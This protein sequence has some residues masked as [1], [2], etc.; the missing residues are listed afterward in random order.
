MS[1]N[2]Y[3]INEDLQ[4]RNKEMSSFS[5]YV[6]GS[7][8]KEYRN[9]VDKVYNLAESIEDN[10]RREKALYYADKYSKSLAEWYNK[11]AEIGTRCPSVL[12]AGPSNFP[13]RKKEKQLAAWDSNMRFL[14]E[15]VDGYKGKIKQII[16]GQEIIHSDEDDAVK[17]LEDKLMLLK[18]NQERMKSA[19][20]ALKLKNIEEGNEKLHQLGYNDLS[21][22][23]LR[24]P[25]YMGRIGFP[26]WQLS[27]NN[28]NIH[29]IEGR[30]QSIKKAK[31]EA[32]VPSD[33]WNNEF[34]EVVENAE[35]MRI[36]L[37]FDGK[38]SEEV[39]DLLKHWGFRWSPRYTAWQRN[40][41]E[42]GKYAVKMVLKSLREGSAA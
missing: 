17:K 42:N 4:R 13:V 23:K 37:I 34:C 12:I 31:E 18:Q 15:T 26:T 5:D 6:D 35:A 41:N 33:K 25:D 20:K 7:V 32:E 40:L 21:I 28:A 19:N 10:A 36:Q 8:T 16:N 30:I 22:Q 38:P 1:R 11:E 2:Y 39:R 29:R 9:S 14:N 24:T 27:N 3:E